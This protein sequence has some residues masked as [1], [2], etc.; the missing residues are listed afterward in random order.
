[1][2]RDWTFVTADP[3]YIIRAPHLYLL[4]SFQPLCNTWNGPLRTTWLCL[5]ERV[6]YSCFLSFLCF[7]SSS[8]ASLSFLTLFFISLIPSHPIPTWL[9]FINQWVLPLCRS[10]DQIRFTPGLNACC[11]G[12]LHL[13]GNPFSWNF[14]TSIWNKMNAGKLGS[15]QN[16]SSV[17]SHQRLMDMVP[18]YNV[19]TDWNWN[20][21][22]I[23]P[24]VF[25]MRLWQ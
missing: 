21:P 12:P 16:V 14:C 24:R 5:I 15:P 13:T 11:R 22:R 4:S 18:L 7:F 3:W 2:L 19:V 17:A 25:I 1:M 8:P 10:R 6:C 23:T 9:G 20:P